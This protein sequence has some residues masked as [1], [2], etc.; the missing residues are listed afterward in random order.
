MQ[1][2]A[3][4]VSRESRKLGAADARLLTVGICLESWEMKMMEGKRDGDDDHQSD[5]VTA[6]EEIIEYL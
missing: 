1:N 2:T 4:R 6:R 5:F 3:T